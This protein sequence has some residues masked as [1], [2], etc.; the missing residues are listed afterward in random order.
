MIVP[1]EVSSNDSNSNS[2]FDCPCFCFRRIFCSSNRVTPLPGSLESLER[3]WE[4]SYKL[5]IRS[6]GEPQLLSHL[7]AMQPKQE[8][9]NKTP[10]RSHSASKTCPNPRKTPVQQSQSS[11]AFPSVGEEETKMSR[12]TTKVMNRNPS[13]DEIASLP[14]IGANKTMSDIHLSSTKPASEN[15]G[16][17][18]GGKIVLPP[19]PTFRKGADGD[20]TKQHS[21]KQKTLFR[22]KSDLEKG[23]DN[24]SGEKVI[25]FS[26]PAISTMDSIE[27]R[28]QNPV[29]RKGGMAYDIIIPNINKTQLPGSIRT[30]FSYSPLKKDPGMKTEREEDLQSKLERAEKRRHAKQEELLRSRKLREKA[31]QQNK[32][33]RLGHVN[34]KARHLEARMEKAA[35]KR[36]EQL[37]NRQV[38]SRKRLERVR[39][40]RRKSEGSLDHIETED[41]TQEDIWKFLVTRGDNDAKERDVP[42]WEKSQS[43]DKSLAGETAER[44]NSRIPRHNH[45][46]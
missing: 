25:T 32:E 42:W 31:I 24:G 20:A 35:E 18:L 39:R 43:G 11:H 37:T 38:A 34:E 23:G 22:K 36:Q 44:K 45:T 10:L 3:T 2:T 14:H 15:T 8:K 6:S 33:E 28:N 40:Q 26:L 46:K 17:R 19:L 16:F 21:A 5:V 29:V 7:E 1:E 27:L 9:R 41:M 12:P 13:A 4:T 30:P